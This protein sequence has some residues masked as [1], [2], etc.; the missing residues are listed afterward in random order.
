M[1][2]VKRPEGELPG[3]IGNVLAQIS[4]SMSE[5]LFEIKYYGDVS[6][7]GNEIGYVVGNVLKDMTETEMNDFV[8]GIRH[9]ISLTNGTH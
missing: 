5:R 1:K 7:L 2:N 6:D 9:G 8:H 3:K 4:L